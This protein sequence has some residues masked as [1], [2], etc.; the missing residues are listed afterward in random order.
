MGRKNKN[1]PKRQKRK[2]R[3]QEQQAQQQYHRRHHGSSYQNSYPD[4][5]ITTVV[6]KKSKRHVQ[7]SKPEQIEQVALDVFGGTKFRLD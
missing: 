6:G 1:K 3:R 4:T 2:Q 5:D 7:L